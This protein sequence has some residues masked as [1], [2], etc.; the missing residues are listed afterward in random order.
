M[1]KLNE[2]LREFA[3]DQFYGSLEIKFE[4]GQVVL[5][6]KSETFRPTAANYG[7]SR[8]SEHVHKT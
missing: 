3:R 1:D 4:H 2:L 5:I 7:T 6:R 8:G